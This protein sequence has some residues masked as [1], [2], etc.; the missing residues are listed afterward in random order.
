MTGGYGANN[1]A[2]FR[3][4]YAAIT[5]ENSTDADGMMNIVANFDS[6]LDLTAAAGTE[7]VLR[8]QLNYDA[9][10]GYLKTW[11][12]SS[13]IDGKYMPRQ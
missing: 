11:D 8:L 5:L 2:S 13:T 6:D 3:Q 10:Q 9:A 1:L 12:T 4:Q 7:G